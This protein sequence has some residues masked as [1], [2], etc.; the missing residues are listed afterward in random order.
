MPGGF[1]FFAAGKILLPGALAAA[2]RGCRW[3][4]CVGYTAPF[5]AGAASF[6]AGRD[7]EPISSAKAMPASLRASRGSLRGLKKMSRVR[8]AGEAYQACGDGCGAGGAW[9]AVLRLCPASREGPSR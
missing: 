4:R 3:V 2:A 5:A 8:A 9:V 6:A 7:R 1:G